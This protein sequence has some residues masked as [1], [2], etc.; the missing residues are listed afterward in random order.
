V[1]S[2]LLNVNL[3]ECKN[4]IDGYVYYPQKNEFD[5]EFCY[6]PCKY[7][8]EQDKVN[9]F[10]ENIAVISLNESNCVFIRRGCILC[11]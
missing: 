2:I 7:K 9:E 10:K 6:I 11:L 1:P 8:K 5:I 3:Y 4:E